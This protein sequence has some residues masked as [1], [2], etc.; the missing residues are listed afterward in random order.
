MSY[1]YG[2]E[3]Y[4]SSGTLSNSFSFAFDVD[5]TIPTYDITATAN[6]TEG[7]TVSDGGSF[8][9]PDRNACHGL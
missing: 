5:C 6:P 8:V 3:I 7:G 1:A 9:Y 4:A 2:A